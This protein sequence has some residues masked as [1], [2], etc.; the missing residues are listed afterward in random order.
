LSDFRFLWSN[1]VNKKTARAIR[2]GF[3]PRTDTVRTRQPSSSQGSPDDRSSADQNGQTV[4]KGRN[5]M[6]LP[7]FKTLLA[8]GIAAVVAL[9]G[10]SLAGSETD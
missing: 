3:M 10:A 2:A 4:G 6:K 1:S 8:A 7:V 9:P 5:A